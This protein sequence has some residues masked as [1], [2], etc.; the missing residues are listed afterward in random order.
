MKAMLIIAV[1]GF[2]LYVAHDSEVFIDE[3]IEDP[4][5]FEML[6]FVRA[7]QTDKNIY[8]Y[9]NYVCHDFTNDVL[10]NAKE[11][12]IRAGYVY[13]NCYMGHAIVC[14]ETM[15]RGLYFLEPQL[16]IVF[17]EMEMNR[18]IENKWY[19]VG[20]GFYQYDNSFTKYEIESWN[21][22]LI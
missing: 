21:N 22:N 5:Y 16:D 20:N 1:V 8:D 17:N 11:Q 19:N 3:S 10:E 13:L 15:D 6:N 4:T 18:M 7:D 12:K 2:L 14:F 9:D